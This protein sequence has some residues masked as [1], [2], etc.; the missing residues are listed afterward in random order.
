MY[1]GILLLLRKITTDVRKVSDALLKLQK[2]APGEAARGG[3]LADIG[4]SQRRCKPSSILTSYTVPF[5]PSSPFLPNLAQQPKIIA[6][7]STL[8]L[9]DKS[10]QIEP[11][12]I[13]DQHSVPE[14]SH[15]ADETEPDTILVIEQPEHQ[16][17]AAVGGIMASRMRVRGLQGCIVGG[18]IRDLAELKK[19]DLPVRPPRSYLPTIRTM[20][21]V[22]SIFPYLTLH[23]YYWRCLLHLHIMHYPVTV[24][25]HSLIS[26]IS[27]A[28]CASQ[29]L[30]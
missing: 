17:C 14:G 1:L 19:T 23:D 21:R 28:V 20:V 22:F 30:H 6:Q 15:W 29:H 2:P 9:I 3:Y 11:L 7:I 18:R 13:D 5:A 16:T 4:R 10:D 27:I 25:Y 26:S 8:R 24:C 12:P